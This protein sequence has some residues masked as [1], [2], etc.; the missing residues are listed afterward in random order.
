MIDIGEAIPNSS[1][2]SNLV[3]EYWYSTTIVL[4]VLPVEYGT[5][6]PHFYNV[7]E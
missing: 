4:L 6:Y 5:K 2:R 3:L 7:L 1:Q